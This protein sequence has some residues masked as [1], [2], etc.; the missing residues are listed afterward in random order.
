L[1]FNF[2]FWKR[3]FSSKNHT[4]IFD[5]SIDPCPQNFRGNG[6]VCIEKLPKYRGNTEQ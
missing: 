2:K 4:V 3:R 1:K 6:S 5:N